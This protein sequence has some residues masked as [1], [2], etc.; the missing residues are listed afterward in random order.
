MEAVLTQD[1]NPFR[2]M[3]DLS[4]LQYCYWNSPETVTAVPVDITGPLSDSH[5]MYVIYPCVLNHRLKTE[6]KGVAATDLTD[7][8][9]TLACFHSPELL[10]T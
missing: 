8:L 3:R 10:V 7:V 1:F 4:E 6:D 5:T 2:R 9:F